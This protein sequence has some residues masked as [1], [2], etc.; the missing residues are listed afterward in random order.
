L[1]SG[2]QL[3]LKTPVTRIF[4]AV[5]DPQTGRFVIHPAMGDSYNQQMFTSAGDPV[6]LGDTFARESD[7]VAPDNTRAV[8]WTDDAASPIELHLASGERRV[9]QTKLS[10]GNPLEVR[11]RSDSSAF[12]LIQSSTTGGA[13]WQTRV[14]IYSADGD[15]RG[16]S[17]VITDFDLNQI[18]WTDCS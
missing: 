18:Q 7:F 13:L 14:E 8:G 15:F 9:L 3:P 11:W 5:E 10:D 12:A 16:S 1:Q 17:E 4:Q 2:E 6:V